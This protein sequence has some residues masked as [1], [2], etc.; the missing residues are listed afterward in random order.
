MR[1][2]GKTKEIIADGDLLLLSETFS[3]E[4]RPDVILHLGGRIVSKRLADFLACAVAQEYIVVNAD[5]RRLDPSHGVTLKIDGYIPDFC[6]RVNVT[7]KKSWLASWVTAAKKIEAIL[8]RALSPKAPAISEPAI[9]AILS[10]RIPPQHILFLG[11]SMPIRDMNI[12]AAANGPC[13]SVAANRGASGIDGTLATALG[14]ARGHRQ[15]ATAL[16]GDLA[17]LHDLNSLALTTVWE[18]PFVSIVINNNGGGI[19]SFLP[20][21]Q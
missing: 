4:H 15:G 8:G 11:N 7:T 16:I 12:F 9:A 18:K 3:R 20:V 5:P 10:Q 6:R 14:F 13:V 21:A 1:C 19:F 17:L 2:G